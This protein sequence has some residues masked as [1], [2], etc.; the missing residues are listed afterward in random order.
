MFVEHVRSCL[1]NLDKKHRL[2]LL[3][4]GKIET[5]TGVIKLA[6]TIEHS[7]EVLNI[8]D[9]EANT[10]YSVSMNRLIVTRGSGTNARDYAFDTVTEYDKGSDSFKMCIRDMNRSIERIL[11]AIP[12]SRKEKIH[13]IIKNKTNWAVLAI[14]IVQLML[15]IHHAELLLN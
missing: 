7:K 11:K 13:R 2:M 14:V 1:E 5:N 15:I 3:E 9:I 10:R 8:Y 12:E 6:S 4:T